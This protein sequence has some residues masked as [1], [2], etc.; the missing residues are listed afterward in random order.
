[1]SFEDPTTFDELYGM[2]IKIGVIGTMVTGRCDC[3]AITASRKLREGG[4]M[5]EGF[6]AV[7]RLRKSAWTAYVNETSFEGKRFE[8]KFRNAWQ[9][10]RLMTVG[11]E[12]LT[13][14]WRLTLIAV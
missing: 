11:D 6:D 7:V 2:D 3:P 14:E 13:G 8:L 9:P 1:M 4:M 10:F 5:P 12:R